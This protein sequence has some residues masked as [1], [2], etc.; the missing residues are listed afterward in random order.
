MAPIM[1]IGYTLQPTDILSASDN[2][3]TIVFEGRQK[4]YKKY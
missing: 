4:L 1:T 3:F 2:Y